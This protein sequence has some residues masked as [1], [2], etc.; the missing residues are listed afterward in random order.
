[1]NRKKLLAYFCMGFVTG[2]F[3]STDLF[4]ETSNHFGGADI[5]SQSNE[6]KQFLF[7]PP[8]RLAGVLG[9]AYGVLQAV[10]TST[11]KPL[12]VYGGIGMAVN[13]VPKFID[14]VFSLMLP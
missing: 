9:G 5:T 3:I 11:M 14:G 13:I 10:L 1:M 12:I 2:L 6:I 8:M 4:A 7:G